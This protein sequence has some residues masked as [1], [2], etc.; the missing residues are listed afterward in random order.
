MAIWIF[1]VTNKSVTCVFVLN[2]NVTY[3]SIFLMNF[4][5]LR[6]MEIKIDIQTKIL[7]IL[8]IMKQNNPELLK[9][10]KEIPVAIPE[11]LNPGLDVKT[12]EAY[13]NSLSDLLT[14]QYVHKRYK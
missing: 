9:Y 11:N 1:N 5:V 7:A 4:E 14:S 3:F 6:L 12:L 8:N 13:Y 10:I 2:P